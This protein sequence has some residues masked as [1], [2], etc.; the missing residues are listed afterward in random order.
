MYVL[1]VSLDP[2]AVVVAGG[3]LL[4]TSPTVVLGTE[5]MLVVVM[6][7]SSSCWPL[8]LP[9]L[10]V[11]SVVD[12]LGGAA[13]VVVVVVVAAVV[14]EVVG[15][16]GVVVVVE[17]VVVAVENEFFVYS[18]SLHWSQI[19]NWSLPW[20]V[21]V[22]VPMVVVDEV[23]EVTS[24][25]AAL[26]TGCGGRVGITVV[27]FW[28]TEVSP[29][30]TMVVFPSED[31]VVGLP[32]TVTF[33]SKDGSLDES[34]IVAFSDTV[35]EVG[36]K[37][38]W[39]VAVVVVVVAFIPVVVATTFSTDP[40]TGSCGIGMASNWSDL[41]SLA[42]SVFSGFGFLGLS[43]AAVVVVTAVVVVA[44]ADAVDSVDDK[45]TLTRA[46]GS[47]VMDFMMSATVSF[48]NSPSKWMGS[49]TERTWREDDMSVV[50][51]GTV[52]CPMNAWTRSGAME[53]P[54]AKAKCMACI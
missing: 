18:T 27:T 21:E 6:M 15:G 7:L 31:P 50:P 33:C 52:V 11:T 17:T 3:G 42:P 49:V 48:A 29:A 44:L 23:V 8:Y 46:A 9:R 32:A 43:V 41:P 4:E 30:V 54:T 34:G 28:E 39:A 14:A 24:V 12:D 40:A 22:V 26:V 19:T 2:F 37:V 10:F 35:E 20:V 36:D 13:V 1:G 53:P 5:G 47:W 38:T 45:V 16:S 51:L 25:G